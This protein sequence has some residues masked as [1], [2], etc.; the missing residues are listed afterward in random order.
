MKSNTISDRDFELI[1]AYL[2]GEVNAWQRREVEDRLAKDARF[3]L[4]YENL[5]RTRQLLRSQPL[6]RAPRNYTLSPKEKPATA[7]VDSWRGFWASPRLMQ[8][9]SVL[10]SLL[11]LFLFVLNWI[12]A[13]RRMSATPMAGGDSMIQS[14]P[15][16][17][18]A[19]QLAQPSLQSSVPA[20]E[21]PL[22]KGLAPVMPSP[23]IVV[24]PAAEMG[25]MAGGAGGGEDAAPALEVP[26]MEP[27]TGT[28]LI[29]PTEASPATVP[30]TDSEHLRAVQR[31]HEKALSDSSPGGSPPS[32]EFSAPQALAEEEQPRW[33]VRQILYGVFAI[34]FAVFAIRI[35]KRKE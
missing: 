7:S 4:A 30:A 3:K 25:G 10:T 12:T 15:T 28:L 18:V 24:P 26:L 14:Q 31:D 16:A 34:I 29:A 11:F 13:E 1:S 8:A 6:L 5:A 23:T 20:E 17:M 32:S 19:E 35:G 9:A 33:L 22:S 27:Y 2:D 21:Q